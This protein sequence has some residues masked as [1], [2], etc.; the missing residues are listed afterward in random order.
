MF[1]IPLHFLVVHFPIALIVVA[2]VYDARGY[3]SRN[4]ELNQ[5]GYSLTLWASAG[6][7]S[8]VGTGLQLAGGFPASGAIAHAGMGL[9]GTIVLIALT[10]L[11][12]SA[13]ARETE[14]MDSYPVLWL[15]LEFAGALA[16]VTAAI[17]GHGAVIKL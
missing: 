4:P 3:F 5:T 17:T 7:A 16:I 14:A 2:L 6:A 13:Q 10:V 9:F 12:Y 15:I 1:D 8:A 11:R